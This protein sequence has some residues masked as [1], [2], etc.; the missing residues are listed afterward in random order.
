MGSTLHLFR[1]CVPEGRDVVACV[2]ENSFAVVIVGTCGRDGLQRVPTKACFV[3][4]IVITR[5]R[6]DDMWVAPG[7]P[8]V[9]ASQRDAMWAPRATEEFK[10]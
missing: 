10:C 9:Y 8:T 5:P 1:L 7:L 3:C 4:F 2:G 6:R